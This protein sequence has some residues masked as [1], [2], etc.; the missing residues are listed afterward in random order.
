[1]YSSWDRFEQSIF[2]PKSVLVQARMDINKGETV[3]STVS[4]SSSTEV[5]MWGFVS[6]SNAQDVT[7][8]Q[9]YRPRT[10]QTKAVYEM[11]LNRQTPG[12]C[13][14]LLLLSVAFL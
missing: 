13:K 11:M 3:L 8:M 6:A 10:A 2:G 1:M 12:K 7:E 9:I 5:A 14:R 4:A